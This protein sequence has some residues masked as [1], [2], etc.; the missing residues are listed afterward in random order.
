MLLNNLQK[1]LNKHPHG[2]A[3]QAL[4]KIITQVGCP[5][6]LEI[7]GFNKKHDFTFLAKKHNFTN[8]ADKYMYVIV[9]KKYFI[10]SAENV[11]LQFQ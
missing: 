1:N 2:R 8:L 11:I 3:C 10:F 5:Q 9:A 4:V 7:C 6:D